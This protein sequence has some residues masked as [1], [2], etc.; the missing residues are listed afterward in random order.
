MKVQTVKAKVLEV[1]EEKW[2]PGYVTCFNSSR[3]EDD[4]PASAWAANHGCGNWR[5]RLDARGDE[6]Y[7]DSYY[8]DHAKREVRVRIEYSV[9]GKRY[10]S[11]TIVETK[12]KRL[13]KVF[14]HYNPDNP[15]EIIEA[16]AESLW[17]VAVILIFTFLALLV[18][19]LCFASKLLVA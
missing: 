13:R 1:I 11:E 3:W 8:S 4:H 18:V 9:S 15:S 12:K 17:D 10:E 14:L 7:R 2:Q 5:D 19:L 16:S 6:R